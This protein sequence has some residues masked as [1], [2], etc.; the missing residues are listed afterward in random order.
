MIAIICEDANGKILH[1]STHRELD[2]R[3]KD[4][5]CGFLDVIDVVKVKIIDR[6][7]TVLFETKTVN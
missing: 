2:D 4:I 5:A 1:R 6:N 7:G 3:A